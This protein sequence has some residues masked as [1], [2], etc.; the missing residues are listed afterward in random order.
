V[1][2]DRSPEEAVYKGITLASDGQRDYLYATNFKGGTVDVFDDHFQ[3]DSTRKFVDASIPAGFAPFNVQS[4]DGMLYVTYAKQKGPDNED[5][6]AAPGNGYVDIFGPNGKLV[7]RFASQ[8]TLNSPW[9][10]AEG[11][12][13]GVKNL[14]DK[15][16]IGNFGDGRINI[17][18]EHGRFSGQLSDSAGAEVT[19]PGLWGLVFTPGDDDQHP[20]KPGAGPR[21]VDGSSPK[22]STRLLFTAGPNGEDDGLFGYLRIVNGKE[23]PD[24]TGHHDDDDR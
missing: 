8:G 14:K 22:D 2:A 7:K 6:E 12:R 9:G 1:V 11:P 10:V 16:L 21:M 15:I 4:I 24:S 5:D 19:I 3:Y 18:D 20:G 23:K 13:H 17:F